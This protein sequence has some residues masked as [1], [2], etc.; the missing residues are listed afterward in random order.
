VTASFANQPGNSHRAYGVLRQFDNENYTL[1][2]HFEDPP[3]FIFK[4]N[5]SSLVVTVSLPEGVT[6]EDPEHV[7]NAL[8]KLYK[9]VKYYTNSPHTPHL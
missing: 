6:L 3:K 7:E 5:R 9:R 2:A 4:N 8:L 1:T